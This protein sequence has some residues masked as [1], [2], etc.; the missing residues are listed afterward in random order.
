MR[1]G[2]SSAN[3]RREARLSPEGWPL[4]LYAALLALSLGLCGAAYAFFP[5]LRAQLVLEDAVVEN[6]SIGFYLLGVGT[7]ALGLFSRAYRFK[8]MVLLAVLC[9]LGVLEELSY[10]QR[11][12]PNLEFPT[13]PS[14]M[15]VDALH[16]LSRVAVKGFE[17]L[18]VPW[19]A[20]FLFSALI[21]LGL[22][23]WPLR[24]HLPALLSAITAPR[25]PWLYVALAAG[26]AATAL[27]ID[28][29][30]FVPR[31]WV[32]MEEVLEMNAAFSLAFAASIGIFFA[33]GARTQNESETHRA[34]R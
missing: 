12:F 16:D 25:S 8:G 24:R 26:L 6:L 34:Q 7:L 32:F 20:G 30:G 5:E 28:A 18:G 19:Y 11:L 2:Y 15:T 29:R 33:Q 22:V 13:L 3:T 4:A 27:F 14:G 17:Q 21:L 31:K 9:T 1:L 10:G 23:G